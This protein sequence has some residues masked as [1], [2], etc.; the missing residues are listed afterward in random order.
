MGPGGDA[1]RS[2]RGIRLRVQAQARQAGAAQPNHLDPASLSELERRIL[3]EAFRQARKLQ[4]R[5]AVDYP[6]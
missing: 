1:F 5:L 2:L 3:K 6:G 4:Q